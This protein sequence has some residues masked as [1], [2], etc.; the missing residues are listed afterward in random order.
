MY[1]L[2]EQ[3]SAFFTLLTSCFLLWLHSSLKHPKLSNSVS[4]NGKTVSVLYD[5]FQKPMHSISKS[6]RGRNCIQITFSWCWTQSEWHYEENVMLWYKTKRVNTSDLV[7]FLVICFTVYLRTVKLV[8]IIFCT[9]L[10][11]WTYLL[12]SINCIS[13]KHAIPYGQR[14]LQ[15]GLKFCRH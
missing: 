2:P 15:W 3:R 7:H 8:L 13:L 5:F 10:L 6:T 14:I 11:D 9:V 12:I 4:C 1:W